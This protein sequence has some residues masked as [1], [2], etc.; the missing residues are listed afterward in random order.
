MQRSRASVSVS[1]THGAQGQP[2]GRVQGGRQQPGG[3]AAA[4]P[5]RPCPKLSE[6]RKVPKVEGAMTR[7]PSTLAG[8]PAARVGV[9]DTVPAGDRGVNQ[10]QQLAAGPVGAS[11]PRSRTASAACSMP[12]RS[13]SVAG[14]SRPALAMAWV[15]SKAIETAAYP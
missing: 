2:A 11:P 6:R 8:L 5:D 7:W 3:V 12:S 4:G 9:V 13:A 10:G 1:A 14:N 15:S